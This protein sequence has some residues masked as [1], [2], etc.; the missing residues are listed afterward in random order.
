[1][2]NSDYREMLHILLDERVEFILVG[3]YALGH[4][5]FD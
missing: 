5:R 2:L 3:A 1:M 4:L